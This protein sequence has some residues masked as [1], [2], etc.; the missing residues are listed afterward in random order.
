M[1]RPPWAPQEI[2]LSRPSAARMYD[3]YLGGSHNFA[4]DRQAAEQAIGMWP[5]LPI[6][7]QANRAFLRR[8]VRYLVTEGID[9]FLDIGS[10]IPTVGNVHEVA[11]QANPESRVVYV[12]IDPVA[13]AHSH[14]ILA[15]NP[16]AA[17]VQGDARDPGRL[18]AEPEVQRLIDL[19]RPVAVLMVALLHFIPDDEDAF[20][21]VHRLRDAIAPGSYIAISH[22]SFEGRPTE[23]ESHTQLYARTSTPMMMRSHQD[24]ERFFDGLHLV[25]PGVVYL[26]LW[27]PESPDEVD[28]H[29]ER[30]TGF[31]G[32]AR[33][34]Q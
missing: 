1:Q 25:E 24:I 34:G 21:L 12:D 32:V 14:A 19:R 7:M 20:R 31:A 26:P 27:R 11:Q 15:G 10:G 17:V 18:L 13:V 3:Y 2:D 23:S 9:Q 4:I 29:P 6:I 22:A 33:K 8:A 28:E 5:D 30:F 16:R